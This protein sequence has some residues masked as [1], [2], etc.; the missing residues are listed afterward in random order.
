MKL[1][2]FTQPD[3]SAL[4]RAK[5]AEA[6]DL[7]KEGIAK[8]YFRADKGDMILTIKVVHLRR[9]ALEGSLR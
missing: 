6:F 5:I 8:G 3:D 9:L 7:V 4:L 1:E 2:D